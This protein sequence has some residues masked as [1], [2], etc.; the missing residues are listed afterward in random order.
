MSL[1]LEAFAG[2]PGSGERPLL[3]D[4]FCGAGGA[5]MGYY[6]AGFDVVGVDKHRQPHY[7]FPFYQLNVLGLGAAY[8]RNFHL[9]HASPPCQ[10]F[11]Q[12][13][14]NLV[15]AWPKLIEPTRRLLQKAGVP[16]VIENV[17]GAPLDEPVTLCGTMFGLPLRRH[18]LFETSFPI[19]VTPAC[20]H[21]GTV[22]NGD[23]AAVYGKGGKGPRHGA[24]VREAA[25]R[26][27]AP[28]WA[29]AMG[30]DWMTDDELREA[31]PP[32]YTE[33]IGRQ[34]LQVLR[35]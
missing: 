19:E 1:V 30:I 8:L 10:G 9:V 22:A 24:G 13:N 25:P 35:S 32:A 4:L 23:F 15:T 18:R 14:K 27:G 7:P 34:L 21:W 33:Y 12:R 17:E 3:L 20:N 29:T 26:P 2:A 6:R 5:A 16:Y 28:S 31:I 11:I